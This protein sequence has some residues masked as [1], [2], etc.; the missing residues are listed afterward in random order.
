MV[1]SLF[2]VLDN[3]PSYHNLE[4]TTRVDTFLEKAGQSVD[5]VGRQLERLSK[6]IKRL[7]VAKLF[8]SFASSLKIIGD[9]IKDHDEAGYVLLVIYPDDD[10]LEYT[11][12]DNKDSNIAQDKYA[13]QENIAASTDNNQ[14]VALVFTSSLEDVKAAYPNFFADSSKFIEHLDTLLIAERIIQKS[15]LKRISSGFF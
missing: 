11:I 8:S 4:V 10:Q 12:F 3:I 2:T 1:A 15:V 14:I 9:E 6:I 13:Q 7:D 5:E